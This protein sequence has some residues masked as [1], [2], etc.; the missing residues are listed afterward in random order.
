MRK[1]YGTTVTLAGER[2]LGF[3]EHNTK[4]NNI[5]LFFSGS[6]S[7][8]Y[9]K[10]ID[11]ETLCAMDIR[12]IVLERPGYG[13]SSAKAGRFIKD[14]PADICE[15]L[16]LMD[17]D[18]VHVMGYS[19][20]GPYALACASF[21]PENIITATVVAGADPLAETEIY[22]ALSEPAKVLP[23]LLNNDPDTAH[24]MLMGMGADAEQLMQGLLASSSEQDKTIYEREDVFAMLLTMIKHGLYPNAEQFAA[25]FKLLFQPWGFDLDSIKSK[26]HLWYGGKDAVEYHSKNHGEYLAKRIPNSELHFRP[27]EGGSVLWSSVNAILAATI[28]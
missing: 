13:L 23:D 3:V 28:T 19:G 22:Q 8:R 27:E 12:L 6:P 20:G 18:K 17:M 9:F 4:G 16:T 11:D 5:L 7:S 2:Q 26:V 1:Q 25:E 24:E 10:F 15:F 14:W 21:M